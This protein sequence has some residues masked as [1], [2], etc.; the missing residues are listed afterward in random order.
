MG[1]SIFVVSSV[2]FLFAT[3]WIIT[4]IL[5]FNKYSKIDKHLLSEDCIL[6]KAV[7]RLRAWL[8]S[9]TFWMVLEYLFIIIPFVS[10]VIVIYLSRNGFQKQNA[11]TVFSIVSLSFIVFGYAIKPQKHK[12]CYR[13]AYSVIDK[14]INDY[15]V[16]LGDEKTGQNALIEAIKAGE[17]FI[18]YSYDIE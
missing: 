10:N 18:D 7:G 6:K 17:G 9:M 16:S 14:A 1:Y 11:I 2:A 13:K 5:S 3:V 12:K 15:L 8:I 4:L